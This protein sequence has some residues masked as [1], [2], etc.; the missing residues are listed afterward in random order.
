MQIPIPDLEEDQYL[1]MFMHYAQELSQVNNTDYERYKA[2]GRRI[3]KKLRGSPIA[4]RTVAS[5][6]QS[7]NSIDFWETTAN[8]DVLN[9]TR[10]ALWWSYQQLGV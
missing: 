10:G 8:L 1:S 6:L 2:I 9:E 7:N 3:I 5:R 4:G